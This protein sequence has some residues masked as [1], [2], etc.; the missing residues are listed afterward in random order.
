MGSPH[1]DSKATDLALFA[2]GGGKF[3]QAPPRKTWKWKGRLEKHV[4]DSRANQNSGDGCY[5]QHWLPRFAVLTDD[6]LSFMHDE[7]SED[8]TDTIP[9]AE[10]V[11]IELVAEEKD[12]DLP[13]EDVGNRARRQDSTRNL[14]QRQDSIGAQSQRASPVY[15]QL[16]LRTVKGGFNSGRRYTYR[17][18]ARDAEMLHTEL[19]M[20][21][22]IAKQRADDAALEAEHGL[23]TFSYYRA[24]GSA[25][26]ESDVTQY[27]LAVVICLAFL[28][29]ILDAQFL[30]EEGCGSLHARKK[31]APYLIVKISRVQK[32]EMRCVRFDVCMCAYDNEQG[33]R[34]LRCLSC[35]SS[36]ALQ[37]LHWSWAS[38]LW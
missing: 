23:R 17:V 30:P 10:L 5:G 26:Y 1:H 35:S 31:S 19:Q 21:T 3:S 2:H 12:L 4:L 9:L 6:R 22:A 37:S 14:L 28:V 33:L 13:N 7:N 8:V 18:S 16:L 38:T 29:D 36:F 34:L 27:C 32:C 25:V 11:R 24:K 15:R 20:R